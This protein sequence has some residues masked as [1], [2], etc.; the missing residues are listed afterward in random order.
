VLLRIRNPVRS[1]WQVVPAINMLVYVYVTCTVE[2][3]DFTLSMGPPVDAN[4]KLT[5]HFILESYR[6]AWHLLT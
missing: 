3:L 4:G 1:T 6:Q 5:V 2:I